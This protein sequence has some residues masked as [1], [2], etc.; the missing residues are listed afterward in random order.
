MLLTTLDTFGWPHIGSCRLLMPVVMLA[1]HVVNSAGRSPL[2][3][4]N[5]RQGVNNRRF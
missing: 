2:P 4:A 3:I 1:E 5:R